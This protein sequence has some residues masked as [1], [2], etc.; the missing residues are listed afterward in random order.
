MILFD[1]IHLSSVEVMEKL[2]IDKFNYKS[3]LL[4]TLLVNK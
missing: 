3:T 1:F 2:V 4:M